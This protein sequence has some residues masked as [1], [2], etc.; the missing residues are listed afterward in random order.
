MPDCPARTVNGT[1]AAMS[2]LQ[3]YWPRE[4]IPHTYMTHHANFALPEQGYTHWW[5][6]FNS[7]Q[8]LTIATLLRTI[9][10]SRDKAMTIRNQVLGAFQYFL[11]THCMFSFWNYAQD[12]LEPFFGNPNYSPKN[13]VVE[14]NVFGDLGRN[15]WTTCSC[16][17]MNGLEYATN[18]WEW[19]V[20]QEGAKASRVICGDHIVT[21]SSEIGCAFR[22]RLVAVW[23]SLF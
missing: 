15:N 19:S 8:L 12:C 10:L 1:H 2:D 13:L 14:G 20:D 9:S 6:M 17:I 7:R 21:T 4:E 23:R 22:K 16:G 18:P 5:K 11:R 3:E